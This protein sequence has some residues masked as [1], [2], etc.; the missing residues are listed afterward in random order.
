MILSMV[1]LLIM[2]AFKTSGVGVLAFQPNSNPGRFDY[3]LTGWSSSTLSRVYSTAN[4]DAQVRI[5]PREL[6]F[7]FTPF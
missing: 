6:W 5:F 2:T 7:H 3:K 4:E 1:S